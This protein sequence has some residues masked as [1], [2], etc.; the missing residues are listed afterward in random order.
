MF[1]GFT[2][3]WGKKLNEDIRLNQ[4]ESKSDEGSTK[5]LKVNKYTPSMI[6]S[7]KRGIIN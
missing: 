2:Q 1:R 7:I 4:T 3:E 5:H 6:Q